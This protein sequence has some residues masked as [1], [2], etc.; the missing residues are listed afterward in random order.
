MNYKKLYGWVEEHRHPIFFCGLIT[1][2]L[3]PEIVEKVF[4]IKLPIQ[5]VVLVL[6]L[7]SLAIIQTTTQ[8]KAFSYLLGGVLVLISIIWINFHDN[9][10][11]G[12]SAYILLFFY[13][14]L[15]SYYLFKDILKSS[16]I[17]TSIVIGVFAGYFLIGVLFFFVFSVMD[18]IY[19]DTITV[20]ISSETGVEDTFYFSFITLT[21]IGYGDFAPSSV[22]GQKLAILEGLTGQFYLAIVVAIMVSKYIAHNTNEKIETDF[23]KNKDD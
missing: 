12:W 15:I 18:G 8:K 9:N 21:T 22:L 20:D 6:V 23:T 1:F 2:F 7:T 3:L 10:Y 19:P 11:V 14:S 13:F 16:K 4:L 17:T 5:L